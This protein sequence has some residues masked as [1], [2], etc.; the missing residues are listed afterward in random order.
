MFRGRFKKLA[1]ATGASV[2]V[3]VAGLAAVPTIAS[4]QGTSPTSTSVTTR[5]A[6]TTTAHPLTVT[7]TVAAVTGEASTVRAVT[8]NAPTGTV[9]FTITGLHSGTASCKTS[10]V[11][12]L[13]RKGKATCHVLAGQLLA[14]D[15]P[16]N[17]EAAY[18]GD[19]TFAPS[20]STTAVT[21]AKARTRTHLKIDSRPHNGTAN[22]VTANVTTVHGGSLLTGDVVFSV[23]ASPATLKSKR[24]CT[25]G[26]DVQPLAVT[27]NVGTATC[28]LQ[29]GWFVISKVGPGNKFP[30]GSWNVTANYSGDDNFLTSVGTKSG[31]SKS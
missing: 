18:S 4:A 2:L 17:V 24:T 27:G 20:S 31:H 6:S 1:V 12:T 28:D 21:V 11:V 22:A 14:H 5:P 9:T 8:P 3:A 19:A 16:Y 23:S 29:A 30:H 25:N 7:A 26:G 10:N 13:N 15:S